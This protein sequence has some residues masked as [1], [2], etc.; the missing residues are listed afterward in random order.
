[1]SIE[2]APVPP[3]VLT[4]PLLVK[5]ERMGIE[6]DPLTVR[7]ERLPVVE[8]R[9]V[10]EAVVE[11]RLVEVAL[12]EMKALPETARAW[13]GVVEPIPKKPFAL[14]ESAAVVEVA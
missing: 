6:A 10:E 1:M 8:K 9:L 5:L 12:P 2:R 13:F 4:K 7:V 14:I 3:E 11:K